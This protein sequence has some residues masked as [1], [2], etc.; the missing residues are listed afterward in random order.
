MSDGLIN[1]QNTRRILIALLLL[2]VVLTLVGY[3]FPG[4]WFRIFHGVEY[5]DP[6]GFL[7]RC[8]GNWAMFA[9]LQAIALWRWERERVWLAVVSGVRFSDLLT[10]WSYLWYCTDI[11]WFGRAALFAAGPLNFLCGLYF[12][13]AFRKFDREKERGS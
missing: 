10:D 3:L 6:Q 9:L 5:V 1:I 11:T 8:A 4:F 2:D 12:F 7:R 13:L